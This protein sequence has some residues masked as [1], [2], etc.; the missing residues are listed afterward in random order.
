MEF[1][2]TAS[3]LRAARAAVTGSLKRTA[4]F[5]IT[6][7]LLVGV[8]GSLLGWHG[9]YEMMLIAAIII[10]NAVATP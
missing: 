10:G 5:S 8:L 6:I 4:P 1:L 9:R 3:L 2:M 7:G